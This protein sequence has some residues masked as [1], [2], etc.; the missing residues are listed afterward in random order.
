MGASGTQGIAE[1]DLSE[2]NDWTRPI[3]ERGF[4]GYSERVDRIF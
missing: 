3:N 4:G 2:L 1:R